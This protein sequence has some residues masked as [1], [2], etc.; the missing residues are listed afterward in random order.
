MPFR[1]LHVPRK[2]GPYLSIYLLQDKSQQCWQPGKSH[3]ESG[4]S[5]QFIFPEGCS[6]LLFKGVH[7]TLGNHSERT[8]R[9]VLL[10]RFLLEY[11]H[12]CK[13]DTLIPTNLHL[14]FHLPLNSVLNA[15]EDSPE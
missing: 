4:F 8:P 11:W 9:E 13:L 12:L 14:I 1:N 5:L 6:K 10:L 2:M 3:H 7:L 15:K